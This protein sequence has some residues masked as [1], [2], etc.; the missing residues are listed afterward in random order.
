MRSNLL[1][2][3]IFSVVL[4]LLTSAVSML[5]GR[6]HAA[7]RTPA[8]VPTVIA[9]ATPTPFPIETAP[10]VPTTATPTPTLA[11]TAPVPTPEIPEG[12]SLLLL[13]TGLTALAGYVGFRR[14]TNPKTSDDGEESK[15]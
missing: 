6:V 14:A 4:I 11:P 10:G 8:P 2:I 1:K 9:T 13:A 7:E 5:G 15:K 12:N 3:S